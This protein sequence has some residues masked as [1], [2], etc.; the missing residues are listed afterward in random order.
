M[1]RSYRHS[2]YHGCCADSDKADK[3]KA[4]RLLRRVTRIAIV[5][6]DPEADVLPVLREV[7]N[8]WNFDKDGKTGLDADSKLLRK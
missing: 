3:R 1:S 7:S 5:G 4:N 6:F 2:P 8:I